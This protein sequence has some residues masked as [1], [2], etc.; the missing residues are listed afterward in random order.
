MARLF[1]EPNLRMRYGYGL[2]EKSHPRKSSFATFVS[3]AVPIAARRRGRTGSPVP[4]V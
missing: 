1:W 2:N 3:F 4:V